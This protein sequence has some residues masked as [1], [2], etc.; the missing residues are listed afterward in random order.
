MGALAGAGAGLFSGGSLQHPMGLSAAPI[1][2]D[3]GARNIVRSPKEPFS[4]ARRSITRAR[5]SICNSSTPRLW[6][7]WNKAS[8]LAA[9]SSHQHPPHGKK[10]T[11]KG[12]GSLNRSPAPALQK[13]IKA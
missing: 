10:I 13:T 3:Q 7:A 9:G 11:S 4:E 12:A 8:V 2:D 5:V 1:E 6:I